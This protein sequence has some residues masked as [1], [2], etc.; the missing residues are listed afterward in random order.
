MTI[1]SID[2]ILDRAKFINFFISHLFKLVVADLLFFLWV[3]N[4][5]AALGFL[6]EFWAIFWSMGTDRVDHPLELGD[7]SQVSL[8]WNNSFIFFAVRR[9]S[10]CKYITRLWYNIL[11]KKEA[12]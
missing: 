6:A 8:G 4:A 9:P 7:C 11:H 12:L 1:V 3:G 5:G 10:D 2:G